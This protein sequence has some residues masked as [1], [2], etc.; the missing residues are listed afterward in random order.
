M[1]SRAEAGLGAA[2]EAE[3]LGRAVALVTAARDPDPASLFEF[4][5]NLVREL[6]TTAS[7]PGHAGRRIGCL[8]TH[9]VS[10]AGAAAD[11]WDRAAGGTPADGW[12]RMVG[13]MAAAQAGGG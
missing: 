5:S 3:L 10:L 1:L 2:E 12:L 13:E 9:V 11:E 8:V 6:V 7:D 4:S